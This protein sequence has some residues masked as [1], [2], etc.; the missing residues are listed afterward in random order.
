MVAKRFLHPIN[1]KIRSNH[2]SRPQPSQPEMRTVIH[3]SLFRF[4]VSLNRQLRCKWLRLLGSLGLGLG[5]LVSVWFFEVQRNNY[6]Y[7]GDPQENMLKCD[8]N[9]TKMVEYWVR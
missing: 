5:E 8:G 7:F 4:L 3:R 1:V 2:E 9:S 6:C